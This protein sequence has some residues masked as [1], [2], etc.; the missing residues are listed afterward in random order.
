MHIRTG[1]QGEGSNPNLMEAKTSGLSMLATLQDCSE[2]VAT[3]PRVFQ[4]KG[5]ANRMNKKLTLLGDFNNVNHSS[6]VRGT[7]WNTT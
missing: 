7:I 3:A 5:G 1:E 4:R 2:S 6:T